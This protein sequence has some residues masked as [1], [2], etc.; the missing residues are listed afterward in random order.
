MA[1]IFRYPAGATVSIS[2]IVTNGVTAPTTSIEVGGI[3]PSGDLSPLQTDASGR[4]ITVDGDPVT[5]KHVIVDSSALPTGAATAAN[6]AT[7][8]AS[9]ASI[10][11]K[12][13]SPLAVTGPLRDAQFRAS[14][15]P[16]SAASLPL[17]TGAATEANQNLEINLLTSIDSTFANNYGAA[18]GAVRTASQIGNASGIADFNTGVTGA[19]TLRVTLASDTPMPL[20]SGGATAANQATEIASLASIDTKLTSPLTV[21]GPLTDTQ[22]RATPVPVS[23]TVTANAGT[24]TFAVSAASLPLPTGAATETTLASIDTKTPALGQALAAASV[25]VV[26]TAAQLASLS[27]APTGRAKANAPIINDYTSTP[28][29]SA[30]YVQLIASTTSDANMV[31]IFDSSGVTLYFAV[32]AAASEVDQ[33]IITP[34]GNGQVSL[35]IPAGSRVSVKATSTS[36]T[37][38]VIVVNLYT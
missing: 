20:P 15:V 37:V 24:G 36:A 27:G 30:A 7:E 18:G 5:P 22:L 13:T 33:F 32:G 29:T 9:L 4:L 11:T 1:Q 16:V 26:L 8:I 2:A 14:A 19:Q 3:D 10:D 34:G 38:G 23:G 25:P 31:E 12:L 28:V 17:P 21:T 6:Q 35:A